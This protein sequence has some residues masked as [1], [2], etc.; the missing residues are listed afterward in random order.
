MNF[1]KYLTLLTLLIG[2]GCDVIQKGRVN[3][4][5]INRTQEELS[6]A[7]N[8]TSRIF[9]YFEKRSDKIEERNRDEQERTFQYRESTERRFQN[10]SNF[11]KELDSAMV[12]GF[13]YMDFQIETLQKNQLDEGR[14]IKNLGSS[15]LDLDEKDSLLEKN[16]SEL[17]KDYIVLSIDY[18]NLIRLTDSLIEEQ[19]KLK[20]TLIQEE[21]SRKEIELK[22]KELLNSFLNYQEDIEDTIKEIE[23]KVA[24]Q[25]EE[26]IDKKIQEI[27]DRIEIQEEGFNKEMPLKIG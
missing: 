5:R 8:D 19:S 13:K 3:E 26:D 15:L 11:L 18:Q 25:E 22:Y 2:G 1:L 14:R 4:Y 6:D 16:I 20:G 24:I 9:T 27:E 10:L 21:K 12:F 23:N 17:S 7:K